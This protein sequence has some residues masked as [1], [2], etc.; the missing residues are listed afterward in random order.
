MLYGRFPL[1]Q[2]NNQS[3]SS[4]EIHQASLVKQMKISFPAPLNMLDYYLSKQAKAENNNS[5]AVIADC[6]KSVT[7]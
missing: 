3:Q 1:S 5:I 4:K 2:G 6:I 7:K